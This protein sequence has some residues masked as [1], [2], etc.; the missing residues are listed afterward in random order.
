MTQ[1]EEILL[2]ETNVL[3]DESIDKYQHMRQVP[4]IGADRLNEP[5]EI[6]FTINSPGRLV[7]LH[8]LFIF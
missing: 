5:G 8:K 1:N 2:W 6:R 3:H 7:H 4:N